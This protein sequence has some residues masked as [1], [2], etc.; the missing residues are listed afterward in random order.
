[1]QQ[2]A[3]RHG[4]ERETALESELESGLDQVALDEA[5][6][7]SAQGEQGVRLVVM[8]VSGCGKSHIGQQ[9]AARLSGASFIDGDDY[10]GEAN[11]AKMAQGTPL[12]DDDRHDWLARLVELIAQA[13]REK[14][15][16]VLACSSL[17]RRYRDQLRAG[18]EALGFV[19]L[20]GSRALLLE[21]LEARTDHFFKGEAML[22]D[23]LATLE[24]P[25]GD[26]QRIHAVNI[27]ATPSRLVEEVC[28]R[29]MDERVRSGA[30]GDVTPA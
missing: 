7:A 5:E 12:N 22:D 17:K 3:D 2:H 24:V 23:Q 21:R 29:L 1:M 13:R 15:S 26:E 19:F 10:H 30:S 14:R 20:D 27:D 6:L 18:D 8:G 16:L 4:T 9:L 28:Q 11:V 25:G